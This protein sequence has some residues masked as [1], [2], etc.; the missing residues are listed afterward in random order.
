MVFLLPRFVNDDINESAADFRAD[1]GTA[2]S[3]DSNLDG[4][5]EPYRSGTVAQALCEL[6]LRPLPRKR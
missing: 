5:I 3:A 4:R 2:D 6:I 1:R